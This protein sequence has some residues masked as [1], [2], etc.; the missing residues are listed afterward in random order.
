MHG[1]FV[2]LGI[3]GCHAFQEYPL[4]GC[5]ILVLKV[6]FFPVWN[7]QNCRRL[8]LSFQATSSRLKPLWA[9]P[10]SSTLHSSYPFQ[11]FSIQTRTQQ[12]NMFAS[13][14]TKQKRT[15]VMKKGKTNITLRIRHE[16]ATSPLS[17]SSTSNNSNI[18]GLDCNFPTYVSTSC[19][20]VTTLWM[21]VHKPS[22]NLQKIF[23]FQNLVDLVWPGLNL[24]LR[25][26]T[27][28][29]S[30]TKGAS[31]TKSGGERW[32]QIKHKWNALLLKKERATRSRQQE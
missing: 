26:K 22:L 23:A 3:L 9:S 10:F 6:S 30:H 15:N 16:K 18:F 4:P 32:K 20:I 19:C 7:S 28:F 17:K 8:Q 27:P 21:N 14:N 29:S 11:R 24:E 12:P 2:C 25:L 31:H 5:M 1:V 13:E